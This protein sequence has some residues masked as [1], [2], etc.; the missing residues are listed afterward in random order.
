[1]SAAVDDEDDDGDDNFE[2]LLKRTVV[3]GVVTG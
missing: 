1:M 3:A 2:G